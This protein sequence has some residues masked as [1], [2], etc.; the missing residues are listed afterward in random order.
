MSKQILDTDRLALRELN[1]ADAAF[2]LELVNDPAWL[3]FIGDRGVRTLEDA[4]SFL[5]RGPMTSYAQ[6]GF[7]SW[8]VELRAGQTP[9]GI[10]GLLKRDT[11]DDIDLGFAFLAAHRRK[12]YASEA[13]RAT[14]AHARETLHVRRLVAIVSPGNEES[15]RLLEKLGFAFER[16]VRLTENALEVNLYATNLGDPC[17][18]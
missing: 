4:R 17:G 10:C 3:R 5:L 13:A 11:L 6:F 1:T 16:E 15:R 8:L 14:M 12:G 18:R 9:V 7:G 2:I